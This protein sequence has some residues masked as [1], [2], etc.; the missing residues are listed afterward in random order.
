M[1][2]CPQTLW[3]RDFT[4]RFQIFPPMFSYQE[5]RYEV[6]LANIVNPLQQL[7]VTHAGLNHLKR[8]EEPLRGSND[9][10]A[11]QSGLRVQLSDD[12]HHY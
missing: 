5:A 10:G 9:Q 11:M 3:L 4:F 7:G 8:L 12:T 6:G 2:S 1:N